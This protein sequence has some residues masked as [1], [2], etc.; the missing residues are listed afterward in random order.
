MGCSLAVVCDQNAVQSVKGNR[1]LKGITYAESEIRDPKRMLST[2]VRIKGGI[3]PLVPVHTRGPIPKKYLFELLDQLKQIEL[4]APVTMG[5][6]VL[7]DACGSGVD[8]I[9]SRDLPAQPKLP[10]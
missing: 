2:T 8:V 6:L 9:A 10:A 7:K 3:H 1:C 5:E 4:Q